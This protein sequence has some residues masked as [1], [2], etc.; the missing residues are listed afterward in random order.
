MSH[1]A[2][3]DRFALSIVAGNYQDAFQMLSANA[4][5]VWSVQSLE[6]AFVEMYDD[7]E[8]AKP[9][10]V[11]EWKDSSGTTKLDRGTLLY[12]PIESEDPWSEAISVIID[13]NDEIVEVEF[14][15][16]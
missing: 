5:N 8:V 13:E 16:P 4:K 9:K 3:A 6:D 10:V 1:R 7:I 2:I 14:G 12:I 11:T 15:R